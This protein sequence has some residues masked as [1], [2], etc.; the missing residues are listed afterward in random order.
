[1][2][3]I[4]LTNNK[5]GVGK[6]TTAVSLA[7][8]LVVLL[9]HN[10]LP[11][12]VLLIDTDSQ[13]HATLLTTGHREWDRSESLGEVLLAKPDKAGALLQRLIVKSA[14]DEDLH[15]LPGSP[16]LDGVNARLAE[17]HGFAVRL[18][19]ALRGVADQYDW[20]VIDTMPSFSRLTTLA[21]VAAT[22]IVIPVEMRFLETVGLQ[23]IVEKITEVQQTWEIPIR[24]TGILPV[25][26]DQRVN[27]ER[28]NLEI[29]TG[30]N[31]YGP[32]LFST[33]IPAN[34]AISYAHD[35]FQSIFTYDERSN[36]ARAYM[37]FIRELVQRILKP[38]GAN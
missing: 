12:R 9:R 2:R 21:M 13:A 18:R 36:A 23:A 6:T 11:H 38:V 5:G 37:T 14:W 10:N 31:F 19:H 30:H 3:S 17:D 34:V 25:K 24:L 27:L 32:R 15:V 28:E 16:T 33:P 35:A 26:Y 22:D 20:V 4:C 8:G 29:Y 7:H 1:M